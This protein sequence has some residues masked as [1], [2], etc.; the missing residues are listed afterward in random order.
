MKLGTRK[1]YKYKGALLMLTAGGESDDRSGA[2]WSD[3][4][5]MLMGWERGGGEGRLG[6]APCACLGD[7]G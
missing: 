1:I 3:T 6:E 4:R 2:L 5:L 7:S